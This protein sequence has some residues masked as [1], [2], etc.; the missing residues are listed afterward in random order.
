MI[1]RG[2]R[3]PLESRSVIARACS[4]HSPSG[5]GAFFFFFRANIASSLSASLPP[6]IRPAAH[7]S[8]Q[9]EGKPLT[10]PCT[11]RSNQPKGSRQFAKISTAA[12]ASSPHRFLLENG[13]L[14]KSLLFFFFFFFF[15]PIMRG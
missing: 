7:P 2:E 3:R 12:Q 4:W 15:K 13:W 14:R 9:E 1:A 6:D 10:V 8:S 11:D 5:P